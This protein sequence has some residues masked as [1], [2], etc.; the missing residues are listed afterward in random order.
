M[1]FLS[2][3]EQWFLNECFKIFWDVMDMSYE[4]LKEMRGVRVYFYLLV[5]M[6]CFVVSLFRFFI[7]NI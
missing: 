1:R 3:Y 7:F 4:L 2:W 5:D 6:S